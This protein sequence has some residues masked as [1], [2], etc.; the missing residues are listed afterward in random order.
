MSS[1]RGRE[2]LPSVADHH[3]GHIALPAL[4]S[5]EIVVS[6]ALHAI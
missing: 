1:G 5:I 2:W 4:E 6:V 3:L